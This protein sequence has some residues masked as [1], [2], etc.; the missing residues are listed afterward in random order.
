MQNL[1]ALALAQTT[2][3]AMSHVLV[4][5]WVISRGVDPFFGGGGGQNHRNDIVLVSQ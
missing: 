3:V 2:T 5:H 1:L 4:E